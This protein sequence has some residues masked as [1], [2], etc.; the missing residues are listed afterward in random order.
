MKSNNTLNT[1]VIKVT[2][3]FWIHFWWLVRCLKWIFPVATTAFQIYRVTKSH[4]IRYIY[5]KNYIII[6]F[7]TFNEDSIM[8][9]SLSLSSSITLVLLYHFFL[10]SDTWTYSLLSNYFVFCDI[11][12]GIICKSASMESSSFCSLFTSNH[13]LPRYY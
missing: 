3:L 12:L 8:M 9:K 10:F 2:T 7:L 11:L 1:D 6:T 13:L 4:S 5:A